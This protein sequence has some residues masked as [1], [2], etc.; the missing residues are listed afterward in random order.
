MMHEEKQRIERLVQAIRKQFL[1]LKSLQ[2]ALEE[3]AEWNSILMQEFSKTESQPQP[4][5]RSAK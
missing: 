1:K 2:V 3:A 4:T 5:I